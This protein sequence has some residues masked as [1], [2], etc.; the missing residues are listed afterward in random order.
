MTEIKDKRVA[1]REPVHFVAELELGGERL[2]CGVSRDASRAGLLLLT[3]V[4]PPVGSKLSLRLYVPHEEDARMLAATVVRC[5][6]IPATERV[7]WAYR[8]GVQLA[9]APDDLQHVIDTLMKPH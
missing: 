7:V 6:K 9:D 8:L 3:H 5:E 2:G 4:E 1:P